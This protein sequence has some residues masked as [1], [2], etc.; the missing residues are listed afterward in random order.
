M[1]TH[2]ENQPLRP[3]TI[4]TFRGVRI[5]VRVVAIGSRFDVEERDRSYRP[6]DRR[7]ETVRLTTIRQRAIAGARCA[8]GV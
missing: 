1:N 6:R 2:S 8:A 5:T 7:W 4:A 3:K